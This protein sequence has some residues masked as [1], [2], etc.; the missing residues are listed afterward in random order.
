MSSRRSARPTGAHAR[1]A[2][3]RCA[4]TAI[5]SRWPWHVIDMSRSPA[6]PTMPS[7]KAGRAMSDLGAMPPVAALFPSRDER[8]RLDDYLT[9]EL[10]LANE[11]IADGCVVPTIDMLEFR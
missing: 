11:R 8:V 1:G 9:R 6:R 5:G 10:L 4:S 2:T 3:C 7:R